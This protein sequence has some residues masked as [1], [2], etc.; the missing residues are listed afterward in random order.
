[1][2]ARTS[3]LV[4]VGVLARWVVVRALVAWSDPGVEPRV[5]LAPRAPGVDEPT[6]VRY[7]PTGRDAGV[8][9][10]APVVGRGG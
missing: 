10:G 4:V 3:R 9:G 5:R 8:W 1:M 2:S 7:Q 6:V